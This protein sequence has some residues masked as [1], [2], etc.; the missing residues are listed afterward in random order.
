M[1]TR[2]GIYVD[3]EWRRTAGANRC[4]VV[5]PHTEERWAEVTCAE[6]AEVDAAVSAAERAL[7]GPWARMS[8]DQRIAIVLRIRDLLEA[9]KA[10][11]ALLH[12]RSM[13]ALH[14]HGHLLGGVPEFITMSVEAARSIAFEYLRRDVSGNTLITRQPIGV[15]AAIVPWNAPLRSE[16]KKVIPALLCGCTVV[17]KPAPETPFSAAVLAEVC[18]EAGVP[19]GVINVVF[20]AAE[21]GEALVKHPAVRK[22]A[23]TGSTVAGAR[24]ASLASSSFKRLQLELGGKSAA[25]LLDDV[26]LDAAMPLLTA[27]AWSNAGQACSSLTRVLVPRSRYDEVIEGFATAARSQCLG[28]PMDPKTTI[29]PLVSERQHRRVLQYIE[30]GRT[31]GARLVMGGGR[32]EA[33]SRGY[34]V[35]P[36]AFADVRNDMRIAQEEIFGPVTCLIPYDSEAE[37]VAMAN[38]SAYGL[39]GGVFGRDEERALALVRQIDTGSAVV[40]MYF[41]PSSAPFGGVKASGMG[42]EHGPEGFDSFLEYVSYNVR[43][44]F[45]AKLAARVPP[46]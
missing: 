41:M 7:R 45:A 20:G 26:D 12:T 16:I 15:V 17:V 31:E 3:G 24:I 9:R 2:D 36:T 39:H 4:S 22:I 38:D 29:G 34:Y 11:F 8:L 6:A 23:F 33:L 5:N 28:D 35:A 30:L 21:T 19:P 44:E 14:K 10:D 18:T 1:M 27:S 37:A 42:R 43:A 40:N 13:G 32:P 46:G 25:I